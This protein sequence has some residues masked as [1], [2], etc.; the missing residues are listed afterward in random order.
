MTYAGC[1]AT[2]A[3]FFTAMWILCGVRSWLHMMGCPRANRFYALTVVDH[4]QWPSAEPDQ[5]ATKPVFTHAPVVHL[6]IAHLERCAAAMTAFCQTNLRALGSA[7]GLLALAA[8]LAACGGGGAADAEA[9]DASPSGR[10]R[11]AA[12]DVDSMPPGEDTRMATAAALN[13]QELE[14]AHLAAQAL[15]EAGPAEVIV[16]TADTVLT[17]AT[18]AD[19]T[20][21]RFFNAISGAHFY[22]ASVSERDRVRAQGGAFAYEGPAFQASSQAAQNLSPV[23]RFFNTATGV[24][25]Y[26]ISEAEK[27]YIQQTLPQFQLEGV[28]YY[29]SKVAAEGYRALYR[30]YVTNKG[31]HFYSV[32]ATETTGLAQY[33]PEGVAYY[34]IGTAA[35][36]VPPPTGPGPGADTTCGLASFQA[37]LLQQVNAAR[38]SARSCG[39]VLRSA[40]PAL[41]WSALLQSAAARHSTDMA[42]N[43]F[44]SH[45]GSDGSNVGT[46]A[47]AAGYGWSGVGENIAAGQANVGTVMSGW[48]SSAGHCDNIMNSG[49]NDVALA[50]VSQAG[51]SYGKYWTMV[52]GRR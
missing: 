8:A 51:T 34:V 10:Q 2:V 30:A 35:A 44:F 17:K 24:H 28:A 20:V 46:R 4:S 3:T 49:Y 41:A 48:L 32:N 9:V 18:A 7:W 37:D 52:L 19:L 45:T 43:N 39:G 13:T 47:T 5:R 50:C 15:L 14:R 38:A 22:T 6:S 36:A 1:S 16:P 12:P 25:F 27:N 23:Y 42:Q 26:S 21:F 29:A 31:F 11:V 33:H 40:A